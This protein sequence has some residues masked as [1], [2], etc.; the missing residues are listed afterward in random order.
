MKNFGISLDITQDCLNEQVHSVNTITHDIKDGYKIINEKYY[1]EYTPE[2]SLRLTIDYD[3]SNEVIRKKITTFKTDGKPIGYKVYNDENE[4]ESYCEY[5]YHLNGNKL[6][7]YEDQECIE[8]YDYDDNN[9]LCL[10]Y[11]P[12]IEASD[13]YEYD[14]NRFVVKQL[15]LS[16]EN[17]IFNGL[18]KK[19]T[20]F[21]NDLSGNVLEMKVI[22]AETQQLL[23]TLKNKVNSFGDDIE[24]IGL[25][26]DGRIHS[27]VRYNYKY[28]DWGNWVLQETMNK[29][30]EIYRQSSRTIEY[31]SNK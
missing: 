23:Y 15:S 29:K 17:S 16:G 20:L 30:G 2:G 12:N 1:K 14:L 28:D 3:S 31:F 21:T 5:R 27:E 8:Q 18:S 25:L 22:N 11:Y 13:Y 7:L 26:S 10:I 4:I 24:C 9:N 6:A 19:T